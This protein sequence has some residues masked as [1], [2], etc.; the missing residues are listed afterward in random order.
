MATHADVLGKVSQL[1][2]SNAQ[3]VREISALEEGRDRLDR[4]F[5]SNLSS[6]NQAIRALPAVIDVLLLEQPPVSLTPVAPCQ[7]TCRH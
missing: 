7:I 3:L 2:L 6:L 4:R 1:S 5:E